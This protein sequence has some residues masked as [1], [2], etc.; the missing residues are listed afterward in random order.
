M[1]A[2][3][4]KRVF[5]P[6]LPARRRTR[7][8]LAA[9]VVVLVAGGVAAGVL[10]GGGAVPP[11]KPILDRPLAYQ[12][13]YRVTATSTGSPVTTYEVLTVHRPFSSSDI[14]YAADPTAGSPGPPRSATW[15]DTE[16][17]YT[18]DGTGVVRHVSDRQP[19]LAG[20]D[21]SL[22]IELDG[23][24]QRKLAKKTGRTMTVANRSCEV[25][26]FAEPPVGPIKPL[27][28]SDHDDLCI[29][30]SGLIL[31]ESYTLKGHIVYARSA[32]RVLVGD[33]TDPLS[34]V[35]AQPLPGAG[36]QGTVSPG[37]DTSAPIATPPTP[38]GFQPTKPVIFT[39]PAP[40]GQGLAAR[41]TVWAFSKGP[42][43]ITVEAGLEGGGHYPWDGQQTPTQPVHLADLGSAKTI[44][45]SEGPQV[46]VALG[47]G[48]WLRVTGTMRPAAL[49]SYVQQ[50][51]RA[52]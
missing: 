36:Q 43:V 33:V 29:D 26:R 40:N 47:S 39:L 15:F 38:A 30:N 6:R 37:V 45:T 12:V 7:R 3:R 11:P 22:G 13:T 23:L 5:R 31:S 46:Q 20:S 14:T 21:Q 27:S 10:I 34:P 16:S 4:R 17:L 52:H 32:I 48:I 25:I 44:L 9:A 41:S 19:G 42:D 1:N 24:A 35:N 51:R 8:L 28:G 2:R 50:L 49:L 18:L